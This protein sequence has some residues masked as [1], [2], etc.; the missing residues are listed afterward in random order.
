MGYGGTAVE[1]LTDAEKKLRAETAAKA[2]AEVRKTVTML[3]W[4]GAG[5]AVLYLLLRR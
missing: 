2:Q 5:V 1:Y 4:A 3:L